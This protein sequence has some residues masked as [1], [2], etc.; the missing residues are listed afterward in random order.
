MS[1]NSGGDILILD[2]QI[3]EVISHTAVFHY[4]PV[5]SVSENSWWMYLPN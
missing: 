3:K 4:V 2:N 1:I 5:Y